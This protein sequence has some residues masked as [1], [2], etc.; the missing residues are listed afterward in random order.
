VTVG[1]VYVV[2][3]LLVLGGADDGNVRSSVVVVVVGGESMC[4]DPP[5]APTETAA[6]AIAPSPTTRSAALSPNITRLLI[7]TWKDAGKGAAI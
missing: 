2:Y 3:A 5:H 6:V 4:P 1:F 7:I